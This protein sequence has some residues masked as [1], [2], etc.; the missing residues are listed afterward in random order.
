ME[1]NT[2]AIGFAALAQEARLHILRLLAGEGDA[3]L[4]A[5]EIALRLQLSPSSLSFHV[6]SLE[7]AGLVRSTRRG[8]HLI[9]AARLDGLR[10]LMSFLAETCLGS[11]PEAWGQLRQLRAGEPAP[12]E[13]IRPAFNVLFLCTHN[14]ARSIMAEAILA[15]LAGNRFR[16]YSAG[17]SPA[18][19]PLPEVIRQLR[20]LG[21]DTA[22]LRS[23]SWDDFI[24]PDAPRM[25][26]VIELCDMRPERRRPIIVERAITASWPLPD[27]SR[28]TGSRLEGSALLVELHGIIRRRLEAFIN[29]PFNALDR[30]TLKARL[31]ALG[32]GAQRNA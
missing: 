22:G 11:L 29:L 5:G 3:G 7:R 10:E 2:A 16:G 27:P 4:P 12:D 15:K 9:Y 31:D 25:D 20:A 26:F 21:Y 8:R 28:F 6:A 30:R 13:P 14:A 32:T 17:P 23:K 19:A 1:S 24:G 18:R